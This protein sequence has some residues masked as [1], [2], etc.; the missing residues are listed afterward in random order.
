MLHSIVPRKSIKPIHI[1]IIL[2]ANSSMDEGDTVV[3]AVL[4]LLLLILMMNV[5]GGLALD[6]VQ[7]EQSFS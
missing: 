7:T 3:V 6:S 4:M 5:M 2:A 1:F